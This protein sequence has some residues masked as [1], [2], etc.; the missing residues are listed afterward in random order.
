MLRGALERTTRPPPAS[1]VRQRVLSAVGFSGLAALAIAYWLTYEPAPA[2]R[3]RWRDDVT[4]EQQAALERKYL[5]SNGRAPM[6]RSI[7]YDLLDTR[8][9]NIEALVHDPAVADTHDIDR[10]NFQVPFEAAY[11]DRWM[12]VAHR[13]PVLR[14]VRIRW[15]LLAA[16]G[17]A[18]IVGWRTDR[19]AWRRRK[20]ADRGAGT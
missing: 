11:G 19:E 20:A 3:V 16:L 9:S 5:L 7:A 4:A 13:T 6:D 15:T 14:D 1:D 2:V 17:A 12:W 10:E 18:A 8:R